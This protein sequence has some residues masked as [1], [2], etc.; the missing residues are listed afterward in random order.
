M[1]TNLKIGIAVAVISATALG[2]WNARGWYESHKE[3]K[4]IKE[5]VVVHNEGNEIL[6][7]KVR[8]V[9]KIKYKYRDKIIR[10]PAVNIPVNCPIDPSTLLRNEAHRALDPSLFESTD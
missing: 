5:K 6:E 1:L 4:L 10:L 3:N 2:S 9:E 7:E 8:V